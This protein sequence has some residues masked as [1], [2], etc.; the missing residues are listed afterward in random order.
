MDR[1]PDNIDSKF[2]FVLL[3][4]E[5]AEQLLAGARPKV[6]DPGRKVTHVAMDEVEQGLVSWEMTEGVSAPDAE[7]SDAASEEE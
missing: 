6:D 1:I 4:A 3:A 2:R 7:A 5:R